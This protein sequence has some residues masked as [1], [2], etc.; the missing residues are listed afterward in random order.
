MLSDHD[1]SFL[2]GIGI[3]PGEGPAL[4]ALSDQESIRQAVA[5]AE[6]AR[7]KFFAAAV[8]NLAERADREMTGG[9]DARD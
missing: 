9:L 8:R 4:L 2:Q 6:E 1:R 3:A 5:Q 7:R